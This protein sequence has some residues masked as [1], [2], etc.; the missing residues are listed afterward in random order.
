VIQRKIDV[1]LGDRSYPIYV[2]TEMTETFAATCQQHGVPKRVVVITDTNVAPHYL[3]PLE[4]NLR[5]SDFIV[6]SIVLSPGE[7]QKSL[8]RAN[9]IYTEMLKRGVGRRCALVA[10]G[11][12]VIGDLVGFVA[13]TYY[14]GVVFL[15][16]PTTLLSQVDSSVGG[17]VAVNHP[18]GKNM[19][20]AFYQPRFVWVDI[21]CLKTLPAREVVC[22]LGEVVKYGVSLDADLFAYLESNL[23]RVLKL[24]R[25]AVAHVQGRCCELK[26][27]IVAEDERETGLR[28]VLNYGHT[29]GH[30]LEAAGNFRVLKHGEAVLLGMIAESYIAREMSLLA[31]EAHKRIVDLIR[32]IPLKVRW[33]SIAPA[34]VLQA[35]KHDKK[36]ADGKNRFVLPSRLGE[37]QVVD[38]VEPAVIQASL[39]Y[40]SREKQ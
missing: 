23:E 4:G 12:G 36:S 7:R 28:M 10:L 32:R 30:A 26:A 22:G 21:E 15:Q 38:S 16:V 34:R 20:G 29:V 35:L 24:E 18:L 6:S 8:S 14:R 27:H 31:P 3:K 5:A 11:G 13:A 1:A 39:K 40:I 9:L 2:G 17:K 37:V 33:S 19:I 25:E